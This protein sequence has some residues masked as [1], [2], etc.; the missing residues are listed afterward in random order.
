[1]HTNMYDIEVVVFALLY[2]EEWVN[3]AVTVQTVLEGEI[4]GRTPTLPATLDNIQSVRS[5]A[6]C[7]GSIE[8]VAGNGVGGWYFPPTDPKNYGWGKGGSNRVPTSIEDLVGI[9]SR[10]LEVG[11]ATHEGEGGCLIIVDE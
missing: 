4:G 1:M 9:V 7:H 11:T 2:P 8:G 3:F 5:G 10:S 6:G